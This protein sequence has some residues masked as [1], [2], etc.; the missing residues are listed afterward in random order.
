MIFNRWGD[1][2]FEK[3][4]YQNDWEGTYDSRPLPPGTYF[5]IVQLNKEEE[6]ALKGYLSIVR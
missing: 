5:Y 2:V 1:K 4:S 6:E 3:E